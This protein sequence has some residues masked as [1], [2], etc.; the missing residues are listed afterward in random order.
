MTQPDHVPLQPPD[1]VRPSDVLS[2]P[3][4]WAQDRPADLLELRQPQGAS[5]GSTGPNLGYGLKLAKRFEEELVLAD[6]EDVHDAVAGCF[7]CG[8]KRAA[9]LGR[10]P[11]IHDM[12]WAYSLWGY[13][14]TPAPGLVQRRVPLFRGASHDYA[15]QRRIVDAVAPGAFSLSPAAVAERA[16]GGEW[17]SLFAAG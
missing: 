1:R 3:L 7:V 4:P 11:V 2:T 9:G 8:G 14:G 15:D 6:G 17:S 12:R 10:A 13:L 16:A 5:F